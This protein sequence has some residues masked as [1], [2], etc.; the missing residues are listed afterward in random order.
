MSWSASLLQRVS[1]SR[2]LAFLALIIPTSAAADESR[3]ALESGLELRYTVKF[4]NWFDGKDGKPAIAREADG[5][6]RYEKSDPNIYVL[7]RQPDG[8]FRVVMQRYSEPGS[9][10]FTW[11]DMFP[12]GRLTLIPSAMP[13]LEFDSIR[14]NFPLLP[15][16]ESERRTGWTEVE[17]R[18]DVGMRFSAVD[19]GIK[20]ECLGPLDRA[21][22][23]KILAHA[24][25]TRR[26][27]ERA[28]SQRRQQ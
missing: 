10:L 16:G 25:T 26:A 22:H 14:T 11:A 2:C 13:I 15:K 27:H 19:G 12:D 24:V 8:S 20:A 7:G 5:T 28:F 23:L 9:P 17:P 1:M 18:T 3:F 4:A 6:K 21:G